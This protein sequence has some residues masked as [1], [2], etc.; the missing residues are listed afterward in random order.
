MR[1]S[2]R[3]TKEREHPEDLGVDGRVILKFILKTTGSSGLD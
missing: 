3:N 2:L 1:F